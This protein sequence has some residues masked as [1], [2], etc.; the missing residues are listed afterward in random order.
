MNEY[1][2][3][4]EGFTNALT[5]LDKFITN[6]NRISE[7]LSLIDRP[8]TEIYHERKDACD[9]LII[10]LD[11]AIGIA[12]SVATKLD[13]T[14]AARAMQSYRLRIKSV[15]FNGVSE[16]ALRVI[17]FISPITDEFQ[18]SGLPAEQFTM[19]QELSGS[20]REIM[21]STSYELSTRKTA[22]TE[23][24]ELVRE[25]RMI[26][27]VDMDNFVKSRRITFPA[28]YNAYMTE[29]KI[30]RHRRKSIT[31]SQLCEITGT[32]TD[33]ATGL[34]LANAV[35]NLTSPETILYTDEDGYY[36]VEDLEAGEYT[37]NC[38]LEGYDVPAGVTVTAAAGESL[39][40]D[41]AL[42]PAQQPSA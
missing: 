37:V 41:F 25:N 17:D 32:V 35:I 29:R 3:A 7:L 16:I 34:P 9:R 38:H 12:I 23:L 18:L 22:K 14:V 27:K 15:S 5:S 42:V 11:D 28:L 13:N 2:D 21:Q 33:S 40:V 31:E 10:A 24:S 39:V 26:L 6:T 8:Y 1:P 4:F 36:L 30:K 20:F 19:L